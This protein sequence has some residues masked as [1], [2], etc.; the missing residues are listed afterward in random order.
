[1]EIHSELG[2]AHLEIINSAE[3][4]AMRAR[5][6]SL[7]LRALNDLYDESGDILLYLDAETLYYSTKG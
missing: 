2:K 6:I 5:L 4:P 7:A 1:M 3:S